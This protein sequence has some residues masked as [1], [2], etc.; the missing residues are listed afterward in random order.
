ME[1]AYHVGECPV[2]KDWGLMEVLYNFESSRCS[3]MCEECLLEFDTLIDFLECK[4]GYRKTYEKA[5]ARLATLEEIVIT[6]W[7]PYLMESN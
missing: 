7:Y 1:Y 2:C 4:N 3:I 5:V 6:E